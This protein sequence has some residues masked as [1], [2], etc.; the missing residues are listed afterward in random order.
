MR[1]IDY[2]QTYIKKSEMD[3]S[4]AYHDPSLSSNENVSRLFASGKLF[5]LLVE[6]TIIIR[7]SSIFFFKFYSC[8]LMFNC[9]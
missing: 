8:T 7:N 9:L 3:N 2:I 6:L 1:I 5:L 4:D